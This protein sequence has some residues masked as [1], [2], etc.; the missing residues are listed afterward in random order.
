MKPVL[1]K[2]PNFKVSYNEP[3]VQK[4]RSQQT[5]IAKR[6]PISATVQ[7]KRRDFQNSEI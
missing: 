3:K 6:L 5:L 7:T 4:E 1:K 2:A